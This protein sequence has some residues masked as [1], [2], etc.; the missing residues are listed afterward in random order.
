[1]NLRVPRQCIALAAVACVVPSVFA[2]EKAVDKGRAP[3]AEQ[4]SFSVY[5]PLQNRDALDN[6]IAA[7]HDSA[8]SRYHQWLTSADF[9]AKYAPSATQLESVRAQLA[10]QGL[11]V[12]AVGPQRLQVSGSASAVEGALQTTLHDG[13]FASGRKTVMATQKPTVSGAM[14]QTGAIV[15][16][17]SGFVRARSFAHVAPAANPQNRYST[18]GPYWFTDLKQAYQWP[19]YQVYTGKGTTIGILMTGD[20]NPTDVSNYFTH[21]KITAPSITTVQ[22]NGGAPYDPSGSTETHLD[23][24]QSGGMAP[25]AKIIFYNMPDLSDDSIIAALAQVVNDNKT[26]VVSMSFGGPEVFYKPEYNDGTDFTYLL[27][28]ED[29]LLAQ[30]T[31][32]GI[33]FIASSGDAG[34]LTAFPPACFNYGP[35]CGPAL[36]SVEFPASSPHVVGVGGTNLTTTYTS[37]TDLNSAYVSEQ[38]YA[39][40][41]EGDIFYGTSSTGQYWGSGGG[42]SVY[43]KKPLFQALTNTGNAKF[44]TV[45]DVS[46]HMGGCPGG[47]IS[48]N[49]DDSA[50]IVTIGGYNYAV[51]GTSAAAP[52]F[53]GLT[54]LA[55]QRFGKRMGNENYYIYALA[56]TQ[57]LGL[58]KVFHQGIPG[59]NGLYSTTA[60]G[61]NRVLGNGTVIGKQFLLAPLVPAAGTPQTPSNP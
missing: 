60:K 31:A 57:S 18:A 35:D 55:V 27:K 2:A 19:S 5:L 51:I 34:A 14:A 13:A 22:I 41:L 50:D 47:A 16:G 15:T 46:L 23:L 17:L 61:Y 12:T 36:P 9:K 28:E 45:P 54:A 53:A 11:T 43:F 38:A 4:V 58:T 1:M 33:T 56:A 7:L 3:S 10:A 48:C 8:S 21:E 30:G 44:R 20:Y 25:Q 59:F 6:D 24:Q 40:P 32:Q 42:D 37:S 49:A 29:D 52:D 26:D 39:D